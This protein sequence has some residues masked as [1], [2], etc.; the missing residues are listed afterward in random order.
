VRIFPLPAYLQVRGKYVASTWRND[1]FSWFARGGVGG[2]RAS[3]R[4]RMTLPTAEARGFSALGRATC[5]VSAGT[6]GGRGSQILGGI[7]RCQEDR[8]CSPWQ[9]IACQNA[10]NIRR[11]KVHLLARRPPNTW[12]SHVRYREESSRQALICQVSPSLATQLSPPSLKA[13]ALGP[14]LW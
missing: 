11:C 4:L 9:R 10:A 6:P 2:L 14:I 13:E 12:S 3:G 5:R 7:Q 8:A 1:W